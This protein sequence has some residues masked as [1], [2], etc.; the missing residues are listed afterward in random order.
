MNVDKVEKDPY[1][2]DLSLAKKALDWLPF[3]VVDM[4]D[5]EIGMTVGTQFR[6]HPDI[7]TIGRS[8]NANSHVF[9][10]KKKARSYMHGTHTA[11]IEIGGGQNQGPRYYTS[12]RQMIIQRIPIKTREGV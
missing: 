3:E 8:R 1:A 6:G 10:Y 4:P 9:E 5:G 11:S 12:R 2:L 7:M